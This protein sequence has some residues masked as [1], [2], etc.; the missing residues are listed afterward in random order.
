[1]TT[2]LRQKIVE[3]S[4]ADI[5][6]LALG[7][8]PPDPNRIPEIEYFI[9]SL[10]SE[11]LHVEQILKT[12]R[13]PKQQLD[14]IEDIH[15]YLSAIER[16]LQTVD[17]ATRFT[18]SAVL[19]EPLVRTLGIDGIRYL[20]PE[21]AVPEDSRTESY[22]PRRRESYAETNLATQE[23][24][25]EANCTDVILCL[26]DAINEP[27]S[28]IL[29]IETPIKDRGGRPPNPY[30]TFII[31]RAVSIFEFATG[32]RAPRSR[33]GKLV[34]FCETIHDLLG[35]PLDGLGDAIQRALGSRT[36]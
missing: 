27:L 5:N 13:T 25:I 6:E 21:I 1:V 24:L 28:L 17:D 29:K 33:H 22:S 16:K 31:K 30:R 2:N 11:I 34:N 18:L 7:L 26:I 20:Y 36:K 14:F 15:R 8:D 35:L 3:I 32:R 19:T 4:S 23:R 10:F 12:G 9:R